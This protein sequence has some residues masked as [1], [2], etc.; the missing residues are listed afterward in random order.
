M[1][2]PR[3]F[4]YNYNDYDND[5]KQNKIIINNRWIRTKILLWIDANIWTL[6]DTGSGKVTSDT[7][8]NESLDV[9]RQN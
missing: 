5:I 7:G 8:V 2:S 4:N 1:K 3:A 9:V 6:D